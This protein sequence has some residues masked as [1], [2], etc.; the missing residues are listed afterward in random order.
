[1]PRPQRNVDQYHPKTLYWTTRRRHPRQEEA[2]VMLV[3]ARS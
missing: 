2:H 3:V 1:M